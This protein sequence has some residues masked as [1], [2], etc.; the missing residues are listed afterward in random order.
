M[1]TLCEILIITLM[2]MLIVRYYAAEIYLL[3]LE[4]DAKQ[5]KWAEENE[6][7]GDL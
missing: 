7:D 6:E 5:E 1:K 2:L 4:L 3:W